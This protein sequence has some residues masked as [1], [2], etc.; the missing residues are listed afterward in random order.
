MET[1]EIAKGKLVRKFLK[2]KP[3]FGE[4]FESRKYWETVSPQK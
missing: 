1:G 2:R 3:L 4:L